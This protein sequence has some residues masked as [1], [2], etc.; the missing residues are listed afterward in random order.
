M[1][2]ACSELV[3]W[4]SLPERVLKLRCLATDEVD[5]VGNNSCSELVH[6]FS[7]QVLLQQVLVMPNG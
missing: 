5:R 7:L 6:W 3:H 1:S 2:I 4:S